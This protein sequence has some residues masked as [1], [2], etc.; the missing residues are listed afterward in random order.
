MSLKH[1]DLKGTIVP[2]ISIDE[3]EPKSGNVESVIVI[4]FYLTDEPPAK[5]LNTFIQRSYID[6]IDVE[7]SPN[8][9]LEGRYLVFVEMDRNTTF[10]NKFQS[11]IRDIENVTGKTDWEVKTYLSNGRNF[12]VDDP[13][14]FS[15]IILDPASYVTKDKFMKESTENGLREFLKDSYVS[16][17][18]INESTITLTSGNKVVTAELVDV[19]EYDLVVGRN[20]LSESAF[21]LGSRTTEAATLSSMLGD[22]EITPIDNFICVSKRA[23]N[24]IMLLKNLELKY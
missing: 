9:D 23:G 7:V 21:R 18:Q 24:S 17:L 10:P 20:L 2:V 16:H 11:L 5:D 19:G 15:F 1:Q 6:T 22:C 3:F 14:L 12:K 4:A 8:T 13:E